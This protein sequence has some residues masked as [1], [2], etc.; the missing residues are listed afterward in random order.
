MRMRALL[1][2]VAAALFLAAC[3]SGPTPPEPGTP[4]FLWDAARQT[5]H[6]GDLAKTN[7]DLAEL[8]QSDNVFTPRARIWQ[9]VLAGGIACGYSELADAYESGAKMNGAHSLEFH[10]QVTALRGQASHAA[11]DFAE[12]VRSFLAKDPSQD[13]VLAFDAPPG[14]AAE[15]PE[16][17]K[18]YAG[19]VLAD[20]EAQALE[21]AMIERGVIRVLSLA[22]A[23]MDAS[24]KTPGEVKTPRATF[25]YATAK[26]LFD[27]SDVFT[28]KKLDQPQYLKAMCEEALDALHSIPETHDTK[29]LGAKIQSAL[30]KVPGV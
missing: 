9:V 30:K 14:A 27:A 20:A 28:A 3:S 11:T 25:L 22:N 6:A 1:L 13:V 10:R 17:R 8:Q 19:I 18:A 24:V 4:A 26:T 7:N 16:L 5:Y 21:T 12:A 15:P 29:A 2:A 23:G